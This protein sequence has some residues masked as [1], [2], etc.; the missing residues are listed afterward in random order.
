MS[1]DGDA[2]VA[3]QSQLAPM[4]PAMTVRGSGHERTLIV[5]SSV[6]ASDAAI[7]RT[8]LELARNLNLSVVA[9]GVETAEVWRLLSDLGCPAAQ[10]YFLARPLPA[11]EIPGWMADH[12][13]GKLDATASA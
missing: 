9:E 3:L 2:F 8:S 12:R 4:W 1:F 10:G 7:V 11:A 6:S 13:A 5:I